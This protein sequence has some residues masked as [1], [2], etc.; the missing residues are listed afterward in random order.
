MSK[1]PHKEAAVGAAV[2]SGE[3]ES[4][5]ARWSQRKTEARRGVELQEPE[6]ERAPETVSEA[7][8]DPVG[9]AT[10]VAVEHSADP[11]GSPADASAELPPIESLN[12]NSDYSAF[13]SSDVSAD[14]QRKALRK[15][16]QSPKFNVRDGL[17]DYDLDFTNPEPLG[18]IITAEMRHRMRAELE[19]LAGLDEDAE[20]TETVAAADVESD[21]YDDSDGPATETDPEPDDEHTEPS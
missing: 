10:S 20:D 3:P 14:I 18:D 7:E 21:E 9:A 5:L 8:A 13:L 6:D 11:P 16:F 19:K 15:L 12:E 4:F 2:E 1:T 17:D